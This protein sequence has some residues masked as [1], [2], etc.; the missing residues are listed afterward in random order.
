MNGRSTTGTDELDGAGEAW[1]VAVVQW[2]EESQ[3]ADA[4]GQGPPPAAVPRRTRRGSADR[5]GRAERLDPP[6]GRASRRL[7]PHRDA[8]AA[9]GAVAEAFA[10]RRQRAVAW[11]V[12]DRAGADRGTPHAGVPP[13]PGRG[14][15]PQRAPRG[16]L[17]GRGGVTR[18][19]SAPAAAAGTHRI[20]G[21]GH[22]QRAPAG[23]HPHVCRSLIRRPGGADPRSESPRGERPCRG[24]RA[25]LPPHRMIQCAN[26]GC[27]RN[28]GGD[29]LSQGVTP[30]VPSALAVFTSVFGMG[31]GVSPPQLPPETL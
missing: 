10:R 11:E 29:L 2:P 17:A 6:A 15:E 4:L 30:R 25:P 9:R 5:L 14:G 13:A 26:R 3:R 21:P 23:L 24:T 7:R 18:A 28:P 1:P 12:V 27:S 8:A 19:R 16:R 20:D 31:T 22:L